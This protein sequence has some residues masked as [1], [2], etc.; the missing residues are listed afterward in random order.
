VTTVD[1]TR[2]GWRGERGQST[3]LVVS[4]LFFMV[5]FVGVVVDVGQAINRRV[6]LQITADAGAY[7][8]ATAMALGL[9]NMARWNKRM[10]DF[11]AGLTIATLGFTVTSCE[12]ADQGLAVYGR[13]RQVLG[14]FYDSVNAAFARIPRQEA[15]RVSRYNILDLFPGELAL[16]EGAGD[17]FAEWDLAPDVGIGPSRPERRLVETE[18]VP[19]GTPPNSVVPALAPSRQSVTFTCVSPEPPFL[20][21]V[22]AELDVWMR[23][24]GEGTDYFVW[25]VKAPATRAL[26]FDSIFGPD[27]IPEMKAVAVAQPIGGSIEEGRP[28]YVVRMVETERVLPGGRISD[29]THYRGF[30]RVIH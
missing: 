6:A 10:Q 14:T 13:A 18:Q 4:M 15:H 5:L 21:V 22:T 26:M 27:A 23:K 24:A 3:A 9:N 28:E 17:S 2:A 12:V 29:P 30:R 7:T 8:G 19:D 16:F 25:R 1:A 11:W 20:R